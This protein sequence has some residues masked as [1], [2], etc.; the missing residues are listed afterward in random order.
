MEKNKELEILKGF[1]KEIE[2]HVTEENQK[3]LN[4]AKVCL[5]DIINKNSIQTEFYE[6]N[7]I[8]LSIFIDM[9]KIVFMK[10]PQL[11]HKLK[12]DNK[13]SNFAIAHF[14]GAREI[15]EEDPLVAISS[16][17]DLP[18]KTHPVFVENRVNFI[19]GEEIEDYAPHKRLH[20]DNLQFYTPSKLARGFADKT[21]AERKIVA[22]ILNEIKTKQIVN[23]KDATLSMYTKFE[24]CIYCYNLLDTFRKEYGVGIYLIYNEMALQMREDFE[25][26]ENLVKRLDELLILFNK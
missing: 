22:Y 5:E 9:I 3:V 18:D 4:E 19:T 14:F 20:V 21:C 2:L 17:T 12:H 7:V 26:E 13:R 25:N 8:S 24:P 23:L 1:I 16:N 10:I 15:L 6:L 11:E